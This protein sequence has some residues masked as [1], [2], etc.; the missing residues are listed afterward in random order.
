MNVSMFLL[1]VGGPFF[2][3]PTHTR[4]AH[5]TRCFVIAQT[6]SQG[7]ARVRISLAGFV[8][9]PSP[10]LTW[11][12]IKEVCRRGQTSV[13]APVQWAQPCLPLYLTCHV[14]L[15]CVSFKCRA[16]GLL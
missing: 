8:H 14:S 5:G 10:T 7:C 2:G 1:S 15:F 6:A 4:C 3:I 11:P 13:Q 9:C 16:C 12:R